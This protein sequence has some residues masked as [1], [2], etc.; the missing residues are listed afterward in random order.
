MKKYLRWQGLLGF[1]AV[2]GLLAGFIYVFAGW[3]IKLTI[4][5]A[6][7]YAL[8]AEVNVESVDVN[9]SPFT[10]TI[11]EFQ[12]TDPKNP[13]NNMLQFE[14][15]GAQMDLW[16]YLLGRYVFEKVRFTEVAMDQPRQ[17]PGEVYT[18]S[19]E[20]GKGA[21]KEDVKDL[22]VSIPDL[23]T[24]LDN[25][26]LITVQRAEELET[27]LDEAKATYQ[28]SKQA[29]PDKEKLQAYETR[30]KA[31]KETE[32]KTVEDVVKLQKELEALKDDIRADKEQLSKVKDDLVASKDKLVNAGKAL[33]QAPSEDWQQVKNKYQLDTLEVED[34]AHIL[35]GEK[36]R[37]Y[38]EQA[39]ELYA[40]IK[41]YLPAG[42]GDSGEAGIDKV[43]VGRFVHFVD[44]NPMPDWLVK[45]G[46]ISLITQLGR[47]EIDLSEINTQNWLRNQDSQIKFFSDSFSNG[48][49]DGNFAYFMQKSGDFIGDGQW[50]VEDM[51]FKKSE[52]SG[53]KFSLQQAGISAKGQLKLN[54]S[55]I[56]SD[57][58]V[59]LLQPKFTSTS[60][61][62]WIQEVIKS[63]SQQASIPAEIRLDGSAF[64]P[65]IGINS[66]MDQIVRDSVTAKAKGELDSLKTEYQAKLNQ[67]V[68]DKLKLSEQEVSEITDLNAW[69]E[70]SEGTLNKLLE[71]KIDDF[72]EQQKEKL[73]DKAK[74]KLKDKI[75]NIFG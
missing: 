60:G 30:I 39:K 56:D 69:I 23:Q 45:D 67:K 9:W 63:L 2:I 25:S 48:Q 19:S 13:A 71:S 75:G 7:G 43:Q 52:P 59:Q 68:A 28:Q 6:G 4:E 33:K 57:N 29:L 50:A 37:E 1:V 26:N 11:N 70:D 61:S 12:A 36:A 20:D 51:L 35:F 38:T 3:L 54:N 47:V 64:A 53:A 62:P 21:L 27:A 58:S 66:N 15:A 14:Q 41:P 5:E 17:S 46:K 24:L 73:K 22:A 18:S 55:Q 40:F 44:D 34:L 72:K 8:G 31:L 74:D 32:I 16:E 42:S 10:L 49:L 65:S